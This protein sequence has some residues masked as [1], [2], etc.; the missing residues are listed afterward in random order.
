MRD[1]FKYI[2]QIILVCLVTL[3]VHIMVLA[4]MD[5]PLFDNQIITAY[6]GNVALAVLIVMGLLKVPETLQNSRGFL[7]LLGSFLKFGFFFLAF[8]SNFKV[9]GAIQRVE[10]FAFFIPYAAALVM[11]TKC[12]IDRLSK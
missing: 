3:G 7:F 11:E 1:L 9:D 12:L 8:Y 10:F 4:F 2:V 5:K 6:A